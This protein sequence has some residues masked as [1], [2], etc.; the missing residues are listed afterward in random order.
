VSFLGTGKTDQ[1]TSKATACVGSPEAQR[2]AGMTGGPRHRM[3][4]T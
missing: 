4:A 3:L 1:A 2:P